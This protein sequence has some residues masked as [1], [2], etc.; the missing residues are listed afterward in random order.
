[1]SNNSNG[2]A[3]FRFFHAFTKRCA[4]DLG[5]DR[6]YCDWPLQLN[7]TMDTCAYWEH[8]SSVNLNVKEPCI[9]AEDKRRDLEIHKAFNC[10]E[11]E[12]ACKLTTLGDVEET[13]GLQCEVCSENCAIKCITNTVCKWYSSEGTGSTESKCDYWANPWHLK[14]SPTK[15]VPAPKSPFW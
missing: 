3:L 14:G 12:A 2:T 7:G 5:L 10:K 1:M 4:L 11:A 9:G 6:P 8:L 13:D 15:T